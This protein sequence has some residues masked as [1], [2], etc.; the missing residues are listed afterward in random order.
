MMNVAQNLVLLQERAWEPQEHVGNEC[1][2][3]LKTPVWR[4][5]C[6]WNN[7]YKKWTT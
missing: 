3:K 4:Y 5:E 6:S 2:E 1:S 7:R